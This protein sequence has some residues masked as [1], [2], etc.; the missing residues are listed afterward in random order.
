MAALKYS[1]QRETIKKHL[2]M[3][4]DHPTA[5]EIYFSLKEDNPHLSLGT[6]YRNLSL[7][8]QLGEI[9]KIQTG[10]GPD[11]FDGVTAKHAH[12]VCGRCRRI[13]DIPIPEQAFLVRETM[14]EG[15]ARVEE[16]I[17]TVKGICAGCAVSVKEEKQD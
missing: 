13:F 12:F 10:D 5:E 11:R 14:E 8:A 9:R 4:R 1:R 7:L 6:V 16:I 3:R 17:L 2:G 15:G